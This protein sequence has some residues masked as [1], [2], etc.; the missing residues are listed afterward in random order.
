MATT[1]P[2]ACP[3]RCPER[4]PNH[5]QLTIEDIVSDTCEYNPETKLPAF[6]G[7]P[8]YHRATVCAGANGRWHLCDCCAKL[9]E[10]KRLKKT[11]LGADLVSTCPK[12]E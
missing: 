5:Q 12:E 8:C 7:G 1:P 11:T 9:P 6:E 2:L 10:F 3:P 4:C